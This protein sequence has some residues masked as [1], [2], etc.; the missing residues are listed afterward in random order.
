MVKKL[1]RSA[2]KP[3]GTIRAAALLGF[4][5]LVRDSG[6][7]PKTF[8]R[9]SGIDPAALESPDNRISYAAMIEMLEDCAQQLDCPNFGLRLSDYQDMNI[10]GPAALI[11][12]TPIRWLKR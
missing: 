4:R 9:D 7:D 10:L 8:L 1:P 12:T 2:Q 5:R 6:G 3:E 11:A